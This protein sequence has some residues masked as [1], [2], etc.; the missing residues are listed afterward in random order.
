MSRR[1]L[2]MFIPGKL[3]K[4]VFRGGVILTLFTVFVAV[5]RYLKS[6]LTPVG[7]NLTESQPVSLHLD[8]AH[9]QKSV[10]LPKITSLLLWRR[11]L[12]RFVFLGNVPF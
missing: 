8:P 2:K 7:F 11:C 9:L 12:R 10:F 1:G 6:F 4:T 5:G 3:K